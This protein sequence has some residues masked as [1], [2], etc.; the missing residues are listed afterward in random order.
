VSTTTIIH[1]QHE[2]VP[3]FERQLS[4]NEVHAVTFH[5]S[6]RDFHVSLNDGLHMSVTYPAGQE[7]AL[8]AQAR[9]KGVPVK[10]A[11]A[12]SHKT[13]PVHH[14]LRYILGGVL[15]VVILVVL[16][17]LLLGRR[18]ALAEDADGPAAGSEP[19]PPPQ[20]SAP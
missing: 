17:V 5:P 2:S 4:A 16:A 3:A 10:I 11:V 18:R 12:S 14:K 9:A 7:P 8:V 15:V 6:A 19:G 1:F 20:G 13:A